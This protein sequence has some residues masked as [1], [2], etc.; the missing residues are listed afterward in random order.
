M[1]ILRRQVHEMNGEQQ[2]RF[3]QRFSFATNLKALWT[4]NASLASGNQPR[5][6]ERT[7]VAVIAEGPTL[8]D[9]L[10]MQSVPSRTRINWNIHQAF[11][12]SLTANHTIATENSFY[13]SKNDPLHECLVHCGELLLASAAP[14]Y[15][16][17]V[18]GERN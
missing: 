8:Q 14:G 11:Q 16:L 1:L 17:A 9:G 10:E 3:L 6:L 18:C 5:K 2:R 13:G 4:W 7:F 12:E 15:P